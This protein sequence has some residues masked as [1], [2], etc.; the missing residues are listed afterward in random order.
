[1]SIHLDRT[2]FQL[3]SLASFLWNFSQTAFFGINYLELSRRYDLL[4]VEWRRAYVIPGCLWKRLECVQVPLA[5]IL[6]TR[7]YLAPRSLVTTR[8]AFQIARF[9]LSG[10]PVQPHFCSSCMHCSNPLISCSQSGPLTSASSILSICSLLVQF[11][12]SSTSAR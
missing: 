3:L 2:I 7:V 10:F 4:W 8:G 5:L 12:F 9:E 1:M 11:A 6:A